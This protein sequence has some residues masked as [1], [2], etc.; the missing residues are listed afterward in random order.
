MKVTFTD[1]HWRNSDDSDTF[2]IHAIQSIELDIDKSIVTIVGVAGT[3]KSAFCHL[4]Y[5][6]GIPHFDIL[7]VHPV[8]MHDYINLGIFA[9]NGMVCTAHYRSTI[10]SWFAHR[11]QTLARRLKDADRSYQKPEFEE[12]ENPEPDCDD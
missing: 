7:C 9:H 10:D 8:H 11:C 5:G 1:V 2:N 4:T 6:G 12:Q 3:Y